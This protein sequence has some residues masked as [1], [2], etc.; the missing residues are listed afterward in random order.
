MLQDN[1]DLTKYAKLEIDFTE[2]IMKVVSKL[3]TIF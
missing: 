1:I 3:P 2:K